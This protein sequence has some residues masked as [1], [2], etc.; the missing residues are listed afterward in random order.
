MKFI[1]STLVLIALFGAQEEV[2]AIKIRSTFTDDL[3]KSLA[4]DMAKDAEEE[5]PK[6]PKKI[7]PVVAKV[8]VVQTAP[9]T[10]ATAPAALAKKPVVAVAAQKPPAKK[11]VK[12]EEEE[13]PMDNAAI[14]AYSSVIA[15]AAEDSEPTTPVQYTEVLSEDEAKPRHEVLGMDPMGSMI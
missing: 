14:K 8:A 5:E 10:N 11:E 4:E 9:A 13:I 12:T 2:S 6:E 1:T 3:A 15:D 7:A